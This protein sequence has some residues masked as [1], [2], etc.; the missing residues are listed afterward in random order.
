MRVVPRSL[1]G[2]VLLFFLSSA[3]AGA[4]AGSTAQISGTVRDTSGGV[5]PGA[6]VSATQTETGFK[7]TVIT[8]GT[9]AYTLTSL[10]IGPYKLDVNLQGFKSYSR[11]GIVLQVNSS[12]TINIELSLG[13]VEE[14]VLVQ[15]ES[16]LIETRNMGVG[17]VMDNKCI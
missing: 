3:I 12:P 14:T 6:D 17:Q 9:G 1:F 7:R 8:D 5:M 2:S 15:A 4:Q 13:T 11:T 10:P 16:P